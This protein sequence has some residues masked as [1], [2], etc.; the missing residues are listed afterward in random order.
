[1]KRPR[2]IAAE[3]RL[4]AGRVVCAFLGH[5]LSPSVHVVWRFLLAN[6]TV[7]EVFIRPCTRCHVAPPSVVVRARPSYE[8][9][10]E[11]TEAAQVSPGRRALH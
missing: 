8:F 6:D 11:R 1:V 2:T 3:L 10:I 5:R 9:D 7:A 4:A